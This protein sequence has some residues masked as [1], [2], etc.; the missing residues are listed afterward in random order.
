MKSKKKHLTHGLILALLLVMVIGCSQPEEEVESP[1]AET[2]Y[3]D[4]ETSVHALPETTEKE[5]TKEEDRAITLSHKLAKQDLADHHELVNFYRSAKH[6]TQE[7]L[8][9]LAKEKAKK[10]QKQTSQS[11]S[12]EGATS[13]SSSQG[14]LSSSSSSSSTSNSSDSSGGSTDQSDPSTQT[15]PD[16]EPT[17]EPEPEPPFEPYYSASIGSQGL[18]NTYDEANAEAFRIDD[19]EWEDMV[20]YLGFSP[21]GRE[22]YPVRHYY[23]PGESTLYY[24]LN[25]Y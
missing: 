8:D 2:P 24:T 13:S 14:S 16:T 7:E 9:N 15:E 1:P 19:M 3:P 10:D 25:F 17:P 4:E 22:V 21:S 11:P 5:M 18:F 23:A 12:E 6:M 20:E